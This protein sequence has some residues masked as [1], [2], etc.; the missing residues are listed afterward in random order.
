VTLLSTVAFKFN[1]RRYKQL[2][3][4][5][6]ENEVATREPDAK[7]SNGRGVRNLLEAGLNPNP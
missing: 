5:H 4:K 2:L 6:F 7:G 3:Q 1:L